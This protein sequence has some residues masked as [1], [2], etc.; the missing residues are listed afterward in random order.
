MRDIYL[1]ARWLFGIEPLAWLQRM[2][3]ELNSFQELQ[4]VFGW[5]H[6]PLID[7]PATLEYQ[8]IEDVNERRLRDAEALATVVRNAAA[9]VCLEIGTGTGRSTALIAL[10]APTA[11]VYTV[12]IPPEEFEA[13]GVLTTMKLEREEIGSY[14]RERGFTNVQQI[15]ANTASWEVTIGMID[16]AFIDGSHDTKFVIDDTLKV[17]PHI[18][19]GGFI[20]WHDFNPALAKKYHWIGSVCQ[21]V[22]QLVGRGVLR[23]RI[24]HV[25]DSWMGIYQVG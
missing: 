16:V 13:G 9:E 21:A 17:L 19:R 20:V 5:T 10:N 3:I 22:D 1:R 12:N 23:G 18:R 15:F 6:G 14:Y 7:D 24:F 25:R 4:K 2:V 11:R 8:F